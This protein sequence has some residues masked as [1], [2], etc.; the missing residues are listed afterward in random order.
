VEQLKQV[1]SLLREVECDEISEGRQGVT[2]ELTLWEGPDPGDYPGALSA[3]DFTLYPSSLSPQNGERSPTSTCAAP[4]APGS[5]WMK[6]TSPA[7]LAE[8][9]A[10]TLEVRASG[11]S[12]N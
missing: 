6:R 5:P 2:K 7:V 11:H 9:L 3:A 1:C 4:S 12:V 8:N 10:T